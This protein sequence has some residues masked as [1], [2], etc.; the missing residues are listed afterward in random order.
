MTKYCGLF[1]F[2]LLFSGMFFFVLFVRWVCVGFY[3]LMKA[4]Q[5]QVKYSGSCVV[6]RRR[7]GGGWNVAT[8]R[9]TLAIIP[10][11]MILMAGTR[12]HSEGADKVRCGKQLEGTGKWVSGRLM[13]GVRKRDVK[14]KSKIHWLTVSAP[15]N[16]EL[17]S[18]EIGKTVG[19]AVLG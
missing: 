18:T 7:L 3:Y 8:G 11:D 6:L 17:P 2:K 10:W 14:G 1:F 15:K 9:H 13:W 12:W 5:K 19:G 4:E 16:M